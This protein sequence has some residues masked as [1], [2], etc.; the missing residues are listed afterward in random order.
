MLLSEAEARVVSGWFCWRCPFRCQGTPIVSSKVE[1]V[2]G[3]VTTNS[4]IVNLL[5]QQCE[6][7]P[8]CLENQLDERTVQRL[9]VTVMVVERESPSIIVALAGNS[10]AQVHDSMMAVSINSSALLH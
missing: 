6:F 7:I 1:A 9:T 8:S 5:S 10:P 4:L 2:V 3:T